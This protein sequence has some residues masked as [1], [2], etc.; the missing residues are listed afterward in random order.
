ML[1][2][3]AKLASSRVIILLNISIASHEKPNQE[4]NYIILPQ[5]LWK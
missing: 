5:L 1:E 2:D 3:L 4:Y